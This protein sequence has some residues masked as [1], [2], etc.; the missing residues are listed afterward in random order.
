MRDVGRRRRE[1]SGQRTGG[2]AARTRIR[3]TASKES[4]GATSLAD[5]S[6]LAERRHLADHSYLARR[7]RLPECSRLAERSRLP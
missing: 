3:A 4:R 6:H 7:S 5:H 2:P 1:R